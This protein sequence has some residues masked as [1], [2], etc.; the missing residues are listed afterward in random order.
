MHTFTYACNKLQPTIGETELKKWAEYFRLIGHPARLAI[1]LMLYGSEVL[2]KSPHSLTFS[3]I[4][5]I[6]SIPSDENLSYHL[7]ELEKAK[8]ITKEPTKNENG[9]VFPLYH[10]TSFGKSF[11]KDIG[12]IHEFRDTLEEL[13]S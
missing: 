1:V 3:E 6:S 11:L 9:R 5:A 13:S 2:R 10:I 12:I 8:F 7:R 4:K